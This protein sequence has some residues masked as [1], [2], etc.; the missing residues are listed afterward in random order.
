MVGTSIRLPPIQRLVE[1]KSVAEQFHFK[2]STLLL[3]GGKIV[4]AVSWF[5]KHISSYKKLT[6][7]DE[8]VFLHWEWVSKQFLVFAELLETSSASILSSG[9]SSV[10][11]QL[12]EWEFKPAFFYQVV[13]FC[14]SLLVLEVEATCLSF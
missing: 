7:P 10:E 3:H 1:I 14:L 6:G 9:S 2:V 11:G 12:S 5:W 13:Y 4:E 8:A